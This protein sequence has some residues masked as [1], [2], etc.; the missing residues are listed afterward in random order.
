[1]R[2][3]DAWEGPGLIAS[4]AFTYL[5]FGEKD[6]AVAELAK[7]IAAQPGNR[8]LV[9]YQPAFAPFRDDPRIKRLIS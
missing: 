3:I 1:M 8:V 6:A 5:R 2:G 7:F 9:R 4:L